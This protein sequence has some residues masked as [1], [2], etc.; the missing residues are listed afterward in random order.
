MRSVLQKRH[1]NRVRKTDR[2]TA[3][4]HNC[5][6]RGIDF[7]SSPTSASK[8]CHTVATATVDGRHCLA[9]SQLREWI[10]RS[11]LPYYIRQMRAS[12]VLHDLVYESDI[13]AERLDSHSLDYVQ[14]RRALLGWASDWSF[15]LFNWTRCLMHIPPL[16][17]WAI[18]G[19]FP[20]TSCYYWSS[21]AQLLVPCCRMAAA[22]RRPSEPI[23][24][25]Y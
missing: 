19:L 5:A 22:T 10:R 11:L 7:F 16:I 4:C 21:G 24:H 23:N 17:P 14:Y 15:H 6:S 12:L 8:W 20:I 1:I 3:R 9:T 2:Q 25:V 18:M 13:D